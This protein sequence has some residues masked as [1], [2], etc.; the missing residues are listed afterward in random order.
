[1]KIR[2]YAIVTVTMNVHV[3]DTWDELACVNQIKAQAERGAMKMI[4]DATRHSRSFEVLKKKS[5]K[6]IVAEVN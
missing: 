6:V 4:D 3:P 5:T 1:M 2:D